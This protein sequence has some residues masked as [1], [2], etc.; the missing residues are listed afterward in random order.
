MPF[1]L[2]QSMDSLEMLSFFMALNASNYSDSDS[3]FSSDYS[4]MYSDDD[5]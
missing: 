1:F 4:Y 5:Y 2:D 3:E